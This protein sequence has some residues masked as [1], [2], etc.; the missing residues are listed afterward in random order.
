MPRQ[1]TGREMTAHDDT[2]TIA[3]AQNRRPHLRFGHAMIGRSDGHIVAA[4]RDGARHT[5]HRNRWAPGSGREGADDVE[6]A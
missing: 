2:H 1:S 4:C 5:E 6:D 3:A